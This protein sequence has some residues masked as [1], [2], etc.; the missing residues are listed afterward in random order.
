MSTISDTQN[1]RVIQLL[2]CTLWDIHIN[3]FN[4][5]CDS[6][7][8]IMC[9]SPKCCTNNLWQIPK[10]RNCSLWCQSDLG[11]QRMAPLWPIYL[12]GNVIFR[13]DQDPMWCQ[14][15]N[16]RISTLPGCLFILEKKADQFQ[17]PCMWGQ[18]IMK[19][20]DIYFFWGSVLW[21]CERLA[22]NNTNA[23][24]DMYYISRMNVSMWQRGHEWA[25]CVCQG[26]SHGEWAGNKWVFTPVS[27]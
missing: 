2:S 4:S 1:I 15:E 22:A 10:K 8:Q 14:R 26:R 5:S 18:K 19:E 16:P 17:T 21:E 11:S 9:L 7:L 3:A 6:R 13:D 24:N 20:N 25:L 23:V 12:F 27:Y